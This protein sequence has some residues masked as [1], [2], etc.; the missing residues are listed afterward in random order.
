MYK[1]LTVAKRLYLGFFVIIALVVGMFVSNYWTTAKIKKADGELAAALDAA[2]QVQDESSRMTRWL[3]AVEQSRAGL[4]MAMDGLRDG[5][6]ENHS[7]V[8]LFNDGREN[9]LQGFLLSAELKEI[10]G[11]LPGFSD[12][13]S[14]LQ[15]LNDQLQAAEERLRQTWRPRHEG[16]AE[17]L[18]E[19][20]RT[21][22]YWALKVANMI[23]VKSSITE[24]LYE[25]LGD[26]P[27][28]EF[29]AGS[30][31]EGFSANLPDLK[32][33][34]SKA[35]PIN[36]QLW[37]ASYELNSLI[38]ESKWEQARM[39]YRDQVP[40]AIKAMA[41]DLDRVINGERRILRDQQRAVAL[42]NGE[43][44]TL[45]NDVVEIFDELALQ[46]AELETA[47]G[48]G[49]QQ[50][51]KA[52]LQKRSAI[53]TSIGGLQR[54]NLIVTLVVILISTLAA[55]FIT[56]SI[57]KPLTQTVDMI[58]H[59]EK[60]QLN[61][62]LQLKSRDE[63][64]RLAGVLDRFADNLRDE[65][66]TAFDRLA[67]GDF[68]FQ[69]K[70][71]IREPLARA[72]QA[73]QK[74]MGQVQVTAEQI[75][76]SSVQV[77]DSSH[78]LS[79]G[80][81]QSAAALEQVSASLAE[82]AS[83]TR[84]N[85]ENANQAN[86]LSNEAKNS[87]VRGSELMTEMVTAMGDINRSG[88][89]ISK[90]I[91]VID[92]IAFQT[93]LLALNAAVEAARAGQHGKGFAVVAEEVRNLAAR[94][95]KAAKETADLIESSAERTRI[96][97]EIADNT[98]AALQEIVAGATRVSDL[99]A[100]IAASSNEQSEG[101]S[102]VNQGLGQIDQVTQQNAA[103]AE[104]SEAASEELSEQASQLQQMISQFRLGG[105]S[106]RIVGGSQATLPGT[107]DQ[108]RLP[109]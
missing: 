77:S 3:A 1:N 13:L 4:R 45:C 20:K 73:L 89:D 8:G 14:E 46:L 39:L 61:H 43:I 47:S 5:L 62:R 66:L 27:L 84:F 70:G 22:L 106:L 19:L 29:R 54:V 68:T 2:A 74:T 21:Q 109:A 86:S 7:A 25:E 23:F 83:M 105:A 34:V 99:V 93:N 57:T 56:R 65:V 48:A 69:A 10:E 50:A 78:T 58:Q 41:V 98:A 87:A 64:G 67:A 103:N 55:L 38:M 97:S 42:L 49:V 75:N 32:A 80:A 85:A 33:A 17:S 63:I 96:G 72:N 79:R 16:L 9:T 52:I 92:E 60:G 26:T 91:R 28:E 6:L 53:E 107:S 31:Y 104:E 11:Q 88:E 51:S 12:R 82:I 81:T 18:A 35:A 76:A 30:V 59:L 40:P 101:I 90:I 95:A 102:Q 94:S 100:E 36:E 44:K 108:L 15:Q 24:L 71:L 37:D